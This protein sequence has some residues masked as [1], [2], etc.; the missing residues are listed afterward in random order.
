MPTDPAM[1]DMILQNADQKLNTFTEARQ[2]LN[3]ELAKSYKQLIEGNAA[4]ILSIFP[5][6]KSFVFG[7]TDNSGDDIQF[8]I[9]LDGEMYLPFQ[10]EKWSPW[11]D[12]VAERWF[13]PDEIGEPPENC[14]KPE[15]VE[16]GTRIWEAVR[17]LA[18]GVAMNENLHT[19]AYG[20]EN[21]V[22]D[23]TGSWT[24]KALRTY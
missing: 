5:E 10:H 11:D 7:Y 1:E 20:T 24:G 14:F 17:R 21:T 19:Y 8:G 6:I 22:F 15:F 2:N 23:H 18:H 13:C 9:E 16:R 3:E 12:L 4:S